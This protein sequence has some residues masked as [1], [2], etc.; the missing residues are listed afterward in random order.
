MAGAIIAGLLKNGMYPENITASAP[1]QG[2]RDRAAN[3]YGIRVT[4]DN[5]ECVAFGDIVVLA[6]KPVFAGEVAAEIRDVLRKEQIILSIVAGK[7]IADLK[8]MLDSGNGGFS[9]EWKIVRAMPNTPALV[10]AGMTGF[11]VSPGVSIEEKT[12]AEEILRSFGIAEEVPERLM[13]AVM[14]ASGSSPAYIFMLI[15]AMADAAVR[16]GLPRAAAYRFAAQ[17]VKGSAELCLKTGK[18]PGELKDMVCSPGGTTIEGVRVL[19]K[20]GFRGIIMDAMHAVV[21]KSSK[22]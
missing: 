8:A 1:T 6:V 11:C 4:A 3:E 20:S 15:E 5:R 7:T 19:E 16:E 9:R 14:T 18:H 13:D 12:A 2:T 10:G 22:L 17:T 21:E